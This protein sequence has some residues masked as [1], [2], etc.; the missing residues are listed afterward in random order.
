MRMLILFVFGLS[1]LAGAVLFY[2]P[3]RCEA[4][5]V[6]FHEA[7]APKEG[8]KKA[9]EPAKQVHE[10]AGGALR[11][12]WESAA[13]AVGKAV[14]DLPSA[15]PSQASFA[16]PTRPAVSPVAAAP[17][18]RPPAVPTVRPEPPRTPPVPHEAPVSTPSRAP[19]P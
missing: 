16:K 1:G 9:Q 3:L 6:L 13:G 14:G 10:A 19:A 18:S 11:K 5:K 12:V 15:P 7:K 8:A 4:E 2:P 17:P